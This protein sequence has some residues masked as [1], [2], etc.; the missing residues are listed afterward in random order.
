M[1][2]FGQTENIFSFIESVGVGAFE[3]LNMN[4][5]SVI[6]PEVN[7]LLDPTQVMVVDQVSVGHYGYYLAQRKTD[8]DFRFE[9]LLKRMALHYA[10]LTDLFIYLPVGVFPLVGDDMRP[11]DP[12]AQISIDNGIERAILDLK[13]PQEKIHRLKSVSIE[14]RTLEV[15]DLVED[16]ANI[17]P[18]SIIL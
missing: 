7:P 9:P 2:S 12:A 8:A 15:I 14:S 5:L 17:Q 4:S 11:L 18:N 10:N 1:A 6:D 3:L 13:I 16:P